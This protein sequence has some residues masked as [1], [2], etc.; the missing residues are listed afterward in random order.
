MRIQQV[1]GVVLAAVLAAGSAAAE[2]AASAPKPTRIV[3]SGF[4]V[5]DLAAERAWYESK[6]GMS[7]VATYPPSGGEP[8]EYVMGLG[9]G[10]DRAVLALAK[11]A[12]RPAGP[13]GF[14]RVILLAPDAKALAS[15]LKASGVETR[16]VIPDVAYFVLDPE[17][18]QV[19]LYTPPK[20]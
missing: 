3:G 14:S 13:N 18:N 19:E 12:T 20:S 17:G 5:R 9:Q 6:L 7:L 15:E 16:E 8:Y 2:A 4:Y 1:V 10:P 11:S